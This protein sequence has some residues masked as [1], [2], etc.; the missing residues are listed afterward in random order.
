MERLTRRLG[1][2]DR[3][4]WLG[5]RED[6][7][8]LLPAVNV[9][10][11]ASRWEGLPCAMIEA[12]TARIPLVATSVPSNH[13]LVLQGE[14]GLLVPPDSPAELAEALTALLDDPRLARR[15]ATRAQDRLGDQHT[16][17]FLACVLDEIYR[18]SSHRPL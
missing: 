2:S 17:E 13:D 7:P 3:M 14:T 5:Q 6:V 10:A 9:L 4:H 11:M 16:P 8:A 12:I 15:L 18:G 1:L